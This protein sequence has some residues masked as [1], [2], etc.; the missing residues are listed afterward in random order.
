M[1]SIFIMEIRNFAISLQCQIYNSFFISFSHEKDAAAVL[2][3]SDEN[4]C[5]YSKV[6]C[7][8]N[9][10]CYLIKCP[11]VIRNRTF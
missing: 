7:Y 6:S 2:G 11:I 5:T 3:G 9:L 10:L 1:D 8:L 4:F